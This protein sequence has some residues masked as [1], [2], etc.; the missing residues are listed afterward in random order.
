MVTPDNWSATV[1]GH[2]I[3]SCQAQDVL[4]LREQSP[5]QG[6]SACALGAAGLAHLGHSGT[7]GPRRKSW[8]GHE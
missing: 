4:S 7:L 1:Q 6:N 3:R 5:V 8:V 2:S